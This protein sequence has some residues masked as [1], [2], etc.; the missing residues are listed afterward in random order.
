M[1]VRI[2]ITHYCFHTEY[3]LWI[4]RNGWS[5]EVYHAR[6]LDFCSIVTACN[7]YSLL[8]MHT[9][10]SSLTVAN[11]EGAKAAQETHQ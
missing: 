2:D 3:C 4:Q 7:S 9:N 10:V 6:I 11:S 1:H 5:D 8:Y